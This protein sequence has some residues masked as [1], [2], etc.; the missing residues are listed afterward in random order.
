MSTKSKIVEC[1]D[2]ILFTVFSSYI[3]N[4]HN[5]AHAIFLDENL[6]LLKLLKQWE[7]YEIIKWLHPILKTESVLNDSEKTL[8]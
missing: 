3:N 1:N 2:F 8:Q 5:I 4:D 6:I 7:E